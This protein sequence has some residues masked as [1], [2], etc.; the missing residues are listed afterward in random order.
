MKATHLI[1]ATVLV[2]A[3]FFS[4]CGG[5]EYSELDEAVKSHDCYFCK[6][7]VKGGGAK[8]QTLRRR[9]LQWG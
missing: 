3:A 4:G 8:M 5:D 7:E 1:L 9:P 6:E 2:I